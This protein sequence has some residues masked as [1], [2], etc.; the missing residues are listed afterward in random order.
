MKDINL[1]QTFFAQGTA[2][3]KAKRIRFN[4]YKNDYARF[5]RKCGV[6]WFAIID[7]LLRRFIYEQFI[8]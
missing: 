1:E 8:K 7:H 4:I 2:S 5:Q 3:K 6:S